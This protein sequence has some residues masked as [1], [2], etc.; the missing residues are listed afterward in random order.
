MIDSNEARKRQQHIREGAREEQEQR[1]YEQKREPYQR[2]HAGLGSLLVLV[3]DDHGRKAARAQRAFTPG[4]EL[5]DPALGVGNPLVARIGQADVGDRD[6]RAVGVG[7]GHRVERVPDPR[8]CAGGV[9]LR[10]GE[11]AEVGSTEGRPYQERGRDDRV[12]GRKQ[13]AHTGIS[14]DGV[15]QGGHLGETIG[16]EGFTAEDERGDY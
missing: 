3:L 11:R 1:G 6:R 15:Y 13:R 4:G 14:G 9:Y 5:V 10:R 2:R 8:S 16:R 12:G 7:P